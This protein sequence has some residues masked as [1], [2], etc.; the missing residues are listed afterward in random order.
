MKTYDHGS[1]GKAR[2]HRPLAIVVTAALITG[3]VAVVSAPAGAR[4]HAA[5]HGGSLTFALTGETTG[6][7]CLPQAQLASPGIQEAMA[8]YDSLT[9]I[10]SQGK[11]VPYLAKSVTPN[12]TFDEW[13]ITLRPGVKFHDGTPVDADAVKLNLDSLRGANPNLPARLG[14]FTLANIAAVT[15]TDPQTVVV[16]TKTPWPAFPAY[17]SSGRTGIAAPAQ[18][19]HPD[20]C[21][22]NMIG[23]GPFK[24]KEWRQNESLTVERNPDYWQKGYPKVDEI[25]FR[26]VQEAQPRVNGLK[27]GQFDLTQE[28]S[29]L[30]ISDLKDMAKDGET[31]VFISDKGSETA[32]QMLNVSKAPFDDPLARQAV[33]A[34]GDANEINRIRNKSLNTIASGPFPPDN[35]AHIATVPRVHNLKK[36]EALAQEYEQKHGE[37]ISFE[38]LALTAPETIAFAELVK[39]QQ[40]KAGIEVS[41]RTLD[42]SALINDVLAGNFQSA[43]FLNHPGGDPDTQYAWWHSGSPVNFGRINDPVIDRDLE[44]GRV[45]TDPAKRTAIYKDL[46][47]R[48]Q[49]ELY[50]LWAWYSLW[51][52]GYQN[53]VSG[54]KGPPLPGGGGRPF[55]LFNGLIPLLSLT[56]G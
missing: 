41:I 32:Y 49:K 34:A 15:V 55:A 48:F 52:V 40:A 39:E 27:G 17:L 7:W 20:T 12:A 54:V 38:Y 44:Q 50:N 1:G 51:A 5:P 6:G 37:P 31:K 30:Q 26:P 19:N 22:T 18:L 53:D 45:E 25:V 29:S 21:A 14:V 16:T 24:L 35:P 33:A 28:A 4:T 2:R 46:N 47:R 13:T 3:M 36:A 43:G 11:Y 10:N 8:I 9:I 42:L 56:K 23:S